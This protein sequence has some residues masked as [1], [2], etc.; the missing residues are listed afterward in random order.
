ML[1]TVILT[2]ITMKAFIVIFAA[3][4]GLCG[5]VLFMMGV[6]YGVIDLYR[7]FKKPKVIK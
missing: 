4:I 3:V 1:S 6:I 7:S 5:L 2:H